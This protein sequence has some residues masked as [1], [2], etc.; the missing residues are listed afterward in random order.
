MTKPSPQNSEPVTIRTCKDLPEAELIRSMLEAGGVKAFIPD[1][2]S[3]GLW[4]SQIL[5]TNGIRVQVAADDAALA[6]ELL[7]REA[8]SL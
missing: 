3:A 1:E 4:P 8:E 6:K 2:N 7:D 5:D